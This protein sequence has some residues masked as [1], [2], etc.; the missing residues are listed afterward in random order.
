[1]RAMIAILLGSICINAGCSLD[2]DCE[3]DVLEVDDVFGGDELRADPDGP[4][5]GSHCVSGD[6]GLRAV[7]IGDLSTNDS[8]VHCTA[9]PGADIDAVC[10]YRGPGADDF[11]GCAVS[12]EYQP[13]TNPPCSNGMDD[14]VAALGLPESETPGVPEQLYISLNGG[15]VVFTFD[16][17][18]QILCQDV[19]I[20]YEIKPDADLVRKE[21]RYSVDLG[22]IHNGEYRSIVEPYPTEAGG[23]G[24]IDAIWD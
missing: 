7:R 10:V 9:A 14:P 1:M 21:D 4:P 20:V 15:S 24:Y 16:A 12:A 23:K 2:S 22:A 6:A 13:P 5:I 8:L 19:I 11:V 17:G 3:H 18:V